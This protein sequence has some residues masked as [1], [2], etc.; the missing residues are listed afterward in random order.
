LAKISQQTL[1]FVKDLNFLI[2]RFN[3][4]FYGILKNCDKGRV[5]RVENTLAVETRTKD[6][7]LIQRVLGAGC[8]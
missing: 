5:V 3:P 8:R 6:Q 1:V 4:S 7:N 2:E